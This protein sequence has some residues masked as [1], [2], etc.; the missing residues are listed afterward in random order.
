FSPRS[1]AEMGLM[2]YCANEG[3]LKGIEVKKILDFEAALLAYAHSE[4]GDLMKQIVAS[5]DW[6]NDIEAKFKATI[7]KFKSTQTW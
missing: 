5:G 7:E 6:N 4:I 2:L 3:H 1:I